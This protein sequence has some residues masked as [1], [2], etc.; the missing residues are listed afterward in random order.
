MLNLKA[1]DP[2]WLVILIKKGR[3]SIFIFIN[4]KIKIKKVIFSN[5]LS[6]QIKLNEDDANFTKIRI[7]SLEL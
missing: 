3:V 1:D 2:T 6:V 4:I 7:F 5:I